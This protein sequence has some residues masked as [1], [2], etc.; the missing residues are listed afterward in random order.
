MIDYLDADSASDADYYKSVD[1][2]NN[3]VSTYVLMK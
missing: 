1:G 3:W 2:F